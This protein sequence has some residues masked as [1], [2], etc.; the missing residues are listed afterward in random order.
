MA[1][2]H[3]GAPAIPKFKGIDAWTKRWRE[4]IIHSR[5]YRKP[6]AYAGQVSRLVIRVE[7]PLTKHLLQNVL[8]VGTGTSGVD[9]ARDL[10]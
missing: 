7:V 4:K 1:T 6:E 9:I 3:Y 5:A 2:G 8:I 10:R